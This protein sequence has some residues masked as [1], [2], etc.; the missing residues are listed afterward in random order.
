MGFDSDD[1]GDDYDGA[2][3]SPFRT[4]YRFCSPCGLDSEEVLH[5]RGLGPTFFGQDGRWSDEPRLFL[6]GA[7]KCRIPGGG[8][9]DRLNDICQ[10]ECEDDRVVHGL[11]EGCCDSGTICYDFFPFE[12]HDTEVGFHERPTE[13]EVYSVN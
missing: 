2:D 9:G 3:D 5:C 13:V 8:L 6:D 4:P 7:M 1:D 12:F 10:F 11:D